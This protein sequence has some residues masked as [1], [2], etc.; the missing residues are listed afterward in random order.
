M[1]LDKWI[2]VVIPEMEIKVYDY[3]II[4]HRLKETSESIQ[5]ISLP[6][7]NLNYI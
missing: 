2:Y 7:L 5:S 3:N 1:E 4:D 6:Q